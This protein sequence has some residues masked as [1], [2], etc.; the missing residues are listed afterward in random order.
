MTWREININHEQGDVRNSPSG[1][2]NVSKESDAVQLAY[3]I[4]EF[5]KLGSNSTVYDGFEARRLL[6]RCAERVEGEILAEAE[7]RMQA[8]D[9]RCD[10]S[11]VG[12]G[13]AKNVRPVMPDTVSVSIDRSLTRTGGR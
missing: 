2:T 3:D 10:A 4:R 8:D 5:L 1:G 7:R 13:W 11:L 9:D 12:S 6:T